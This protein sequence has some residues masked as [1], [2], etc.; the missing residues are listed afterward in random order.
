MDSSS[1]IQHPELL[2]S[3]MAKGAA[4]MTSF[5]I[6]DQCIGVVSTSILARLLVPADFG[7]V[8]LATSMIAVLEVL[9]AFG[10]ETALVQRANV[11]REHFDSVWTFISYLGW[12][13]A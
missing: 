4:W 8:A 13:W 12:V 10:L 6:I 1:Q 7:L 5:R 2:G 11:S 9:G 3:M